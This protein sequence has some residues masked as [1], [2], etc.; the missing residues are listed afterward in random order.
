MIPGRH[1]QC[2]ILAVA[3]ACRGMH[4]SAQENTE[5]T[6]RVS[7]RMVTV[8]TQVLNARTGRAISPLEVQ[9]FQVY[10]DGIQQKIISFNQDE[11]PLSV[12]F[13]FDL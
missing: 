6:L 10:E 2:V 8:D 3:I 11:L 5:E 13:L 9:D 7:V 4:S 1:I 12:V